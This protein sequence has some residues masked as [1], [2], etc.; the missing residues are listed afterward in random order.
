MSPICCILPFDQTYE[1]IMDQ[2]DIPDL[3]EAFFGGGLEGYIDY[4]FLSPAEHA[5]LVAV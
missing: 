4:P 2:K 3:F 1:M 5:S